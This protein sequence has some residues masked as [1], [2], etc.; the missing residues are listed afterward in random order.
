MS[1]KCFTLRLLYRD[2][3]KTLYHKPHKPQMDSSSFT[4]LVMP[5]RESLLRYAL[6]LAH[7]SDRAE[8]LVQETCMCAWQNRDKLPQYAG[9]IESLLLRIVHNTFID[10]VRRQH[11]E[12]EPLDGH[13]DIASADNA[14]RRGTGVYVRSVIKLLPPLQRQVVVMKE[15]EGYENSEIASILGTNEASVRKNLQRARERM[16]QIILKTS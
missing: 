9:K 16:K 14:A 4:Q 3:K 6:S 10:Q 1:Q 11:M 2:T 5:H 13:Y 7:D 12:C 8:D 15:I